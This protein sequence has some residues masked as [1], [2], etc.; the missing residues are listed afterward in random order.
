MLLDK[1]FPAYAGEEPYVFVCYAHSDRKSVYPEIRWL[2]DQGFNI[3]YDEGIAPGAEF[4]EY[5]GK[6]IL[7]ASLVLFYVSPRSVNSRHCRDEVYFALDHDTP[8][9][10]A[11]LAATEL[12][13]GL[14]LSIGTT[15]G[16]VRFDLPL[17][18]YRT[19]LVATIAA[20]TAKPM[21]GSGAKPQTAVPRRSPLA[22]LQRR[23]VPLSVSAA[24]VAVL[25]AGFAT[26]QFLDRQ[27]EYRW[28]RDD[29]LPRIR[30]LVDREWRDYTEAY[31]LAV[32]AEEIAPDHPDLARIFD[33]ISLD[34]DINSEPAGAAVYMK[35]YDRPN[36][37]WMYLGVTPVRSVRVPVGTF[38]WKFEK[39][40]FDTVL[41]TATSWDI[42]LSGS[43]LLIPNNLGRKLDRNAEI[44]PGMVR[45]AAAQT[46]LGKVPDFFIDRY[47]VTNADFQ[48]FIDAGGYRE[49]KYWRHEFTEDGR[50]IEWQDGI[51]RFVDRTGRPGPA[52]W[53]AGAYP[54]GEARH[55]VSVS[56]YEAAAY[57]EFVGR[58]LPTGTHWGIARGEYSPLIRFPQL[59]GYAVLAPF[60]NF[61]T[62]GTVEVGSLS[63]VTA[64]GAYDLAGNVREWC[65]NDTSLGKL[66]RGGAWEDNPYR[67]AALS[68][69]PPMFREQAYGFRTVLYSNGQREPEAAFAQVPINP[70]ANP[71]DYEVVSDEV[72]DIFSRRFEYDRTDLNVRQES[73]DD[74]SELWTLE[75]VS[76]DA[77]YGDERMIINLFLPKNGAPSHQAV[78]YFPGSA[79]LFQTSSENIDEYY[80]FPVFLSFLVRN[81]RAVVYPVYQGTF[82]RHGE[83]YPARHAD[84]PSHAYAEYLVELVKDFRRTI[85]YLETRDD[86]DAS[87]LAFYGMSWG[88]ILGTIIPAVEDRLS[89][90]IILA[91]GIINAGRPEANPLNY[92][93]RIRL[94]YLM[95]VGRYDSILGYE[96]AARP[97]FDL[98]GTPE[99]HKVMKVYETDHIPSKSDYIA[100]ILAWLDV[101]LGPV[102]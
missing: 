73:I 22:A 79:S 15:Q 80:E 20:A 97:L 17:K 35:E 91:G 71:Y 40:G 82:E 54:D 100:E 51:A 81:G 64:F 8:L 90:A 7:D 30:E 44:P 87:K 63:G 70:P 14:S 28:V 76:V 6:R 101:Y 57:A 16:L 4:P 21:L 84:H 33:S 62:E 83:E 60:S 75:R 78:I 66:V 88:A 29:A 37:E 49:R 50:V 12:P 58:S 31:A 9:L 52:S 2:R 23:A 1:P 65:W 94:P 42:S 25:V 43:D 59:G 89:T 36:D 32:Q 41:A 93:P 38:R 98:I 48:K 77:P 96:A 11:H 72:F 18:D 86:I 74:S 99:E 10:A 56:W 45:V 19:K 102:G 68:Q 39:Q 34:I 3:W 92:V 47:E 26:K 69:A 46:P 5:L 61:G 53:L 24:I 85:D 13:P 95:L 55:P 67:F 27:A